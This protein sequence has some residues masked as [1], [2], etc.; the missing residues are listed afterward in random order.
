MR[1]SWDERTELAVARVG[2]PKARQSA[3]ASRV[4]AVGELIRV[5][6]ICGYQYPPDSPT[7]PVV[8]TY[9]D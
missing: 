2:P 3:G 8:M 7:V 4:A 6:E 9:S 5:R 1:E